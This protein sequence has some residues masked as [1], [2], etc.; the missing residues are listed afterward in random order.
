M[1]RDLLVLWICVL[2]A[3]VFVLYLIDPAMSDWV[4]KCPLK[5]MTGWSCP[6]C[7]LQRSLHALLHGN[8]LEAIRYNYLLVLVVP[9]VV[10]LIVA[11]TCFSEG[12]KTKV[13]TI[14]KSRAVVY[15][16]LICIVLWFIVRNLLHI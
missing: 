1:K 7:G 2:A 16:L 10:L 14:L 6:L 9:Y 11:K 8:V 3:I 5:W 15:F 13:L 12:Y 4:L